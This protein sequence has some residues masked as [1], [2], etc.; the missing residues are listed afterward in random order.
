MKFTHNG[1]SYVQI[2]AT[3][4][5]GP[6]YRVGDTIT[7]QRNEFLIVWSNPQK[8]AIVIILDNTVF[9]IVT[10]S[11]KTFYSWNYPATVRAVLE[12]LRHQYAPTT[13]L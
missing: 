3:I 7:R 5:E 2:P 1:I 8:G 6:H 12:V 10:V 11:T 4:T 9:G 13:I